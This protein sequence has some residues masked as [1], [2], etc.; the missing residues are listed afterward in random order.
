MSGHGKTGPLRLVGFGYPNQDRSGAEL[1][2]RI[3]ANAGRLT[4]EG[5]PSPTGAPSC[6][7]TSAQAEQQATGRR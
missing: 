3:P 6:R 1:L 2:F 5:A 4:F 7:L